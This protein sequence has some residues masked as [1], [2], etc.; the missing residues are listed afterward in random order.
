MF[1]MKLGEKLLVIKN[2]I[3][4]M[5]CIYCDKEAHNE[6]T[7]IQLKE[8]FA[9]TACAKVNPYQLERWDFAKVV[10]FKV[11]SLLYNPDINP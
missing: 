9:H 6:L 4:K 5:T 1:I 3:N 11:L 7:R 8:G 10:N 2:A